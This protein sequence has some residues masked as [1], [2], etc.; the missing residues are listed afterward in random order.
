LRDPSSLIKARFG[1]LVLFLERR[2]LLKVLYEVLADKEK[3]LLNWRVQRVEY[4]ENWVVVIYEDE[5]ECKG[6][7]GVGR[8]GCT[9]L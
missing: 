2:V 3:I 6:D 7:F 4:N 9:L 1:Y 8:M 5:S